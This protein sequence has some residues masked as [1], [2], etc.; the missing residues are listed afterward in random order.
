MN[1]FVIGCGPWANVVVMSVIESKIALIEEIYQYSARDVNFKSLFIR[2]EDVVW[3][4]TTPQFQVENCKSLLEI[5]CEVILEKPFASDEKGFEYL[6]VLE[7][8]Y[9]NMHLS[10]VWRFSDIW[11]RFKQIIVNFE[12]VYITG[13][14]VGPKRR[15]YINPIQDWMAHDIYLLLDLFGELNLRNLKISSSENFENARLYCSNLNIELMIGFGSAKRSFWK[16]G[17]RG[18][19]EMLLDFNNHE[20]KFNPFTSE[21]FKGSSTE[22]IPNFLNWIILTDSKE[23]FNLDLISI[24]LN[25][26]KQMRFKNAIS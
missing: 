13:E 10:T 5:G 14:R 1:F 9:S 17:L 24:C 8:D 4:C 18:G 15:G 19:G 20:I 7:N 21:Y 22:T 23:S 6:K 25:L 11:K 2:E 16:I 3:L 26:N 12:I